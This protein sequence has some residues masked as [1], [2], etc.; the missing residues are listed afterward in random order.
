M[1]PKLSYGRVGCMVLGNKYVP[2]VISRDLLSRSVHMQCVKKTIATLQY[3]HCYMVWFV[4]LLYLPLNSTR[5][6]L[7]L[8]ENQACIL[9]ISQWCLNWWL[10]WF[11]K[12]IF[13]SWRFFRQ[14]EK[15]VII[16]ACFFD[17]KKFSN[18]CVDASLGILFFKKSSG[19][20]TIRLIY[21]RQII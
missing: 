19:V 1:G 6:E 14:I 11:R 13:G 2:K 12:L 8:W 7:V 4:L 3:C 20:T 10:H 16:M 5:K 15:I 9:M 18:I 17:T 21:I